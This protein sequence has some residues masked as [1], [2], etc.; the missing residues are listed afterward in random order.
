M[1]GAF[2]AGAFDDV[3]FDTGSS[4]TPSDSGGRRRPWFIAEDNLDDTLD[5]IRRLREEEEIV[6]L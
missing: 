1:D 5:M 3:A 6:I 2:D 4:I